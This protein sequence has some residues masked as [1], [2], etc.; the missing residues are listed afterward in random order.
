MLQKTIFKRHVKCWMNNTDR[1]SLRY[2]TYWI[3]PKSRVQTSSRL[4]CLWWFHLEPRTWRLTGDVRVYLSEVTHLLVFSS[5]LLLWPA[6]RCELLAKTQ[7]NTPNMSAL[8]A[9]PQMWTRRG[10]TN[11][12]SKQASLAW[13]QLTVDPRYTVISFSN[14]TCN[15]S[16]VREFSRAGGVTGHDAT[17][18]VHR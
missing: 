2:F 12:H 15:M 5:A 16:D 1:T 17:L 3:L 4:F 10:Q 9:V 6:R 14:S 7:T 13:L 18:A 8:L 11:K